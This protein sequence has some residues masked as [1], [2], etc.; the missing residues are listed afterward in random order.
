MTFVSYP[1]VL[2]DYLERLVLTHAFLYD[3]APSPRFS[4]DMR[5]RF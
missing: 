3:K 2:P 4:M 5:M 1:L